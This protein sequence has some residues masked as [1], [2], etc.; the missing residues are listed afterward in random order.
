MHFPAA[1]LWDVDGTIAETERDGHRVAFN[2]AFEAFGLPWHWDDARYGELLHITGGRERLLHDMNSRLDAPAEASKREALAQ[3]LHAKKNTSYAELV[4]GAGIALRG[5][6]LEL[7]TECRDQNVRMAIATTTSFTNVDALMCRQ[8]G[9][10]WVDWFGAIVCGE[11]VK[12]KKPDPEVFDKALAALGVDARRAVAIEDSP[13]GVA[14]ARAANC[15]VIV[16]RSAYFADAPIAGALA[17]GPGLDVRTGWSPSLGDNEESH[18]V[19]LADLISLFR[20]TSG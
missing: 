1:V 13:N 7:M 15:P 19:R 20:A 2:L 14:A 9:E 10:R 18:R 12:R 5:G 6:V 3:A 16:T 4:H 8:I 17:I 11:D